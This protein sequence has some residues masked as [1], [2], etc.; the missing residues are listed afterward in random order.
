MRLPRIAVR[1]LARRGGGARHGAPL[2]L[3]QGMDRHARSFGAARGRP[4]TIFTRK[5]RREKTPMT[6][7]DE[8]RSMMFERIRAALGAER[9]DRARR[10]AVHAAARASPARAHARARQAPRR[11]AASRSSPSM[12]AKQGADVAPRGHAEGGGW[13]HCLLSRHVQPAAARCASVR[14]A[15]LRRFP[16]ARRGTSNA[17]SAPAE[18]S[19]RASLSR[20]VAGAAETGTLFLLSGSDN[21]TTLELPARGA[22][23]THR[24]LRYFRLPTRR[25]S[26]GMRSLSGERHCRA[27]SIS[28][29]GRRGPPISSR[30]SCAA[31][32]ARA[33][34]TSLILG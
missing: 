23:R 11:G 21:P 7:P 15:C 19:D 32:T 1:R 29:V 33:A 6:V 30:P 8:A 2:P 28:S 22:Q 4:F 9:L 18:P 14:T 10:S 34:C 3:P 13:R 12:L 24:R 26:T 20:A 27:A 16:G 17:R 31:R 25:P 5:A